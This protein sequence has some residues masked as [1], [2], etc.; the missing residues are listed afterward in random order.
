MVNTKETRLEWLKRLIDAYP[1]PDRGKKARFAASV[2][3]APAQISQWLGGT[4]SIEDETAREIEKRLGLARWTMD[5]QHDASAPQLG[6]GID[7]KTLDAFTVPP[8]TAWGELMTM[9]KL[10]EVFRVAAPDDALA[11]KIP[12]GTELIMAAGVAPR[13]NQVVLVRDA[14]GTLHLRRY[15]Q[16]AGSNWR[17]LAPNEAYLAL[18]AERDG[19]VLLAALKWIEGEGY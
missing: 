18:E 6:G 7:P 13:P 17:A 11:P 15:G 12:R 19:L 10:P 2:G 8:I 1:G 9:D 4:R 14:A 16:G 5:A 3:K